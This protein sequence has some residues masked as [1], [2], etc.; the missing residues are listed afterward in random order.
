M[1]PGKLLDILDVAEKIK[2][3]TRHCYTRGGRHE[4]VAEHSW[5]MTLRA[6]FLKDEFPKVDLDKVIRMCIIHDL[7]E[8]PAF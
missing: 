2:D 7:G 5:M 6:F 4:S 8:E 3:A 1:E